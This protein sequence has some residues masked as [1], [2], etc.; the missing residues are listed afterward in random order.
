MTKP[1]K[2]PV[3]PA[4]TQ[5]RLGSLIKVFAVHMKKAWVLSF[6]VSAQRRPWSDWGESLLAHRS[7][8]WFCHAE[9]QLSFW[10]EAVSS[11]KK[12]QLSFKILFGYI[13]TKVFNIFFSFDRAEQPLNSHNGSLPFTI[14]YVPLVRLAFKMKKW[15]H[16]GG[17]YGKN[18]R[19]RIERRKNKF[20]VL[21][22]KMYSLAEIDAIKSLL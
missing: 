17:I 12:F 15:L 13:K 14:H 16:I 3:R 19:V 10:Y 18:N 22:L 1:T 2:W 6:P 11:K 20:I 9:A 21:R 7:F 4:K 8:C 5:I